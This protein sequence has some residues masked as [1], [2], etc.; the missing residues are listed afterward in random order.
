MFRTPVY[1]LQIIYMKRI[2]YV[3]T[4]THVCV[5]IYA[6]IH[7]NYKFMLPKYLEILKKSTSHREVNLGN[8]KPVPGFLICWKNACRSM[9]TGEKIKGRSQPTNQPIKKPQKPNKKPLKDIMGQEKYVFVT[10]DR[11]VLVV[12]IVVYGYVIVGWN[13][14]INIT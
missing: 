1:W 12:V 6:E 10:I 14:N 7:K 13:I 2:I 11:H 8:L 3:D 9:T 4:D 5:C